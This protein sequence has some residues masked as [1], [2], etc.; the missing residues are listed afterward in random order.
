ML[1]LAVRRRTVA[2]LT[3]QTCGAL[4]IVSLANAVPAPSEHTFIYS[5]AVRDTAVQSCCGAVRCLRSRPTS[6]FSGIY[7]D[8]AERPYQN[9]SGLRVKLCKFINRAMPKSV[10]AVSI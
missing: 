10:A 7:R 4:C 8:A 5:S 6:Q 2:F 1:G 3:N 9:E